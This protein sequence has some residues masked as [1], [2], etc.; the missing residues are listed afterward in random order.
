MHVVKST[1]DFVP[2]G[3]RTL[4]VVT[5]YPHF[6]PDGTRTDAYVVFL[7]ISHPQR[8]G[9]TWQIVPF[10]N[11]Y[12]KNIISCILSFRRDAMIHSFYAHIFSGMVWT[13]IMIS[14]LKGREQIR[15]LVFYPYLI[16]KVME[17]L[18]KLCHLAINMGKNRNSIKL[19]SRRDAMI[20]SFYAHI[21]SGMVWTS[22]MISSLKGRE[23]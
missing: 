12:G 15:M 18:D 11:K 22:L 10:G 7:P 14:S 16:P 23:R 2:K 4:V 17:L 9:S 20:H 5:F 1:Y 6:A 19:S 3:T 8:D 13:S 21:F